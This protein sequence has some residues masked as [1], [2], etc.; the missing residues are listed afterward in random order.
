MTRPR[1]AI[2]IQTA[3][4]PRGYFTTSSVVGSL[5]DIMGH[6]MSGLKGV[7]VALWQCSRGS[8]STCL[9]I[10]LGAVDPPDIRA[11]VREH[12]P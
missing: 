9:Q 3:R 10:I 12:E 11:F 4:L 7:M 8:D 6:E 5:L 1:F 2:D